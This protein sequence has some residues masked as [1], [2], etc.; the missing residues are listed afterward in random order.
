VKSATFVSGTAIGLS[1]YSISN[2]VSI[3]V[4]WL[5]YLSCTLPRYPRDATS[6]HPAIFHTTAQQRD[7]ERN[8]VQSGRIL[9]FKELTYKITPFSSRASTLTRVIDIAILSVRLAVCPSVCLSVC[10]P[11]AFRYSMETA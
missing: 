10:M 6:A 11:V 5:L 8:S 3:A 7:A 4:V 1:I 9:L 2:D